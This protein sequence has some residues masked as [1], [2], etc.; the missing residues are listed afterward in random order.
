[1]AEFISKTQEKREIRVK[2]VRDIA[3]IA[4]SSII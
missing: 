1:M 4:F 2:C 3:R